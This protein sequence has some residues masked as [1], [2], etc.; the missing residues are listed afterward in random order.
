[1][2]EE[3][4]NRFKID[5]WVKNQASL[6][7]EFNAVQSNK[8]ENSMWFQNEHMQQEHEREQLE[9]TSSDDEEMMILNKSMKKFYNPDKPKYGKEVAFMNEAYRYSFSLKRA[10]SII[11]EEK[12]SI[13]STHAAAAVQQDYHI[14]SARMLFPN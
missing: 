9:D 4:A 7:A 6:E 13:E 12:E 8:N 3:L 14:S 5:D 11:Q 2:I 1:L 10:K